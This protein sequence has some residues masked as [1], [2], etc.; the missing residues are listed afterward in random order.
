LRISWTNRTFDNIK[1][2]GETVKKEITLFK[3]TIL[4]KI[5]S[6]REEKK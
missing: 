5:V 6:A 4:R 2:Q 3:N 1:I